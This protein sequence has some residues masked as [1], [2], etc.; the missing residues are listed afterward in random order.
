MFPEALMLH[1]LDDLDSKMEAMRAQ[2]E[3][4]AESDGAWTGYN[5]SLGRPLL[6]SAKFLAEKVSEE[7][8]LPSGAELPVATSADL[9]ASDNG[10]P[11]LAGLEPAFESAELEPAEKEKTRTAMTSAGRENKI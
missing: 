6:N 3:R 2:F 9:D 10:T 5:A 11:R 4:A 1:Y 7:E 8:Q